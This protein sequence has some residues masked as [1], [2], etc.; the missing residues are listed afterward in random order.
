LPLS[1]GSRLG[2][3]E[4]GSQIGEGGMGQVHRA[5]DTRLNRDVAIKVLPE[6][7]ASD[8]DRLARFTREA[9][10]LASLNHPNIAH[11]HGLEESGS[12]SALVMELVEGEDLAQ[13][14]AR[15]AMPLDEVLPIARQICEALEAAHEQGIIHRDLKPANIKVRPDGTVKVLDFGLAKAAERAAAASSSGSMSPTMAVPVTT[16]AGMVLGTAAYMSPEQA[17]GKAVDKRTDVWAFGCVLFEMLT[18]RRAFDGETGTDLLVAI[19]EREPNWALLPAPAS[20]R[21]GRLLRRCLEKN[22]RQRM[23]DIADARIE[24]E[25]S[26]GPSTDAKASDVQTRRPARWMMPAWFAAG[27][28]A[29]GAGLAVWGWVSAA[30]ETPPM[31]LRSAIPLP[32]DTVVSLGR[33]S[34]VAFAP[35]GRSIV[36]VAASKDSSTSTQ[37]FLRRLDQWDATPIAGTQ[38]ATNPFFSPDGRWVAFFA[39]RKLKKTPIEG[40]APVTLADASAPRGESWGPNDSIVF[41]PAGNS[42]LMR[43]PAAGGEPTAVTKLATGHL[44]HRWPQVLPDGRSVVFTIWNDVGWEPARVAVQSLEGG[45][46]KVVVQGGGFARYV[47]DPATGDG[48]LVYARAEGL[49]AARFDLGRLEVVGQPTPVL[50]GVIT[51]LSGGAH[52][53]VSSTGWLAYVPGELGEVDRDLLWVD[54]SGRET[55]AIRVRGMSRPFTLSPDGTRVLRNNTVGSSRNLWS[56]DLRRGTPT[57]LTTDGVNAQM[58]VWSSDSGSVVFAQGLPALN[59]F[60][61]TSDGRAA[62]E[63]LI[64]S[65]AD[66]IPSSWSRDGRLIAFVEF[67]PQTGSDIWLL[68][69]AAALSAR[70]GGR[71]PDA[72]ARRPFVKTP[73][74]EGNAAF[75]PDG[76]WL[77]YQSNES[78]RFEIYVQPVSGVGRKFQVSTDGGIGPE[79]SPTGREVFY[80]AGD[81]LM[82]AE[83]QGGT[84]FATAAPRPLFSGRY[85]NDFQVSPDGS[86]FLMMRLSATEAGATSLVIVS[87]WLAEVRGKLR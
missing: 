23:H 14:L 4:V 49:M 43:V 31:S 12:T 71:E 48:Y 44:S 36:Y 77:A 32:A 5:R 55:P 8:P 83:V 80:R 82:A 66:N 6:H 34:T 24:L 87:D 70:S 52:F 53:S 21:L 19:V 86:R 67:D 40:G 27:V 50:D 78:G 79:W 57:Q 51:N 73:F 81:Q 74:S 30:P 17:R 65:S 9:Q 1:P 18:G 68:D 29:A 13:L 69:M 37:L 75:S 46:P 47:A 85:E 54:R 7:F 62:P 35:D 76:R 72:A 61:M 3:Y 59:L 60:H 64:T 84:E 26:Q 58:G 42:P 38:G 39:D 22:P 41:T 2:V 15:G 45:E 63:R 25:E 11:I 28:L 20:Q 33:G 16:Q 10:T 56:D